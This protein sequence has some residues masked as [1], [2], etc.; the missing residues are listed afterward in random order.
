LNN[1]EYSQL[2]EKSVDELISLVKQ[3]DQQLLT[4]TE[5]NQ[6]LNLMLDNMSEHNDTVTE[7]LME[8]NEDLQ[9]MI[10][11][12]SEHADALAEDLEQKRIL[13]RQTFGRYLSDEIVNTLLDDENGLKLGGKREQI[14]LL[15]S[16]IRGFTALSEIQE[17]EIVVKILNY[18]LDNME[19]I[20]TKYNGTIDEFMGDGI[21]V[22]FG[23]P[24]QRE[25]DDKRAIA[26]AIE[27]QLCMP[28]INEQMKQWGLP[29]L[30]MGIGINTG[31]VVVGNIGSEN[32][33]KYGVVGSSVNLTYRI[34]SYTLGGQILISQST[35]D[36]V[37]ECIE[38]YD[39]R[40]ITPKGVKESVSIY[41][42]KSIKDKYN[43]QLNHETIV[44]EE[45][46]NKIPLHYV[47]LDGKQLGDDVII[48]EISHFSD[49]Y[50]YI[51]GVTSDVE[52]PQ[53][54]TNI[55]IDSMAGNGH[56]DA[57]Y[58]KVITPE[59]ELMGN[60]TFSDTGVFICFTSNDE[61]VRQVLG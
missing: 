56:K 45:L 58:A 46:K 13:I 22:L 6:D 43:L 25:D 50:A 1:I 21:L 9:L 5:E 8:D 29:K 33:S 24:T 12:T 3:L 17:P 59:K 60:N 30:E 26:C 2:H 52:M 37:A 19:K 27:M 11:T 48:G 10:E 41:S 42:V 34:E 40:K 15:T 39:V 28:K 47:I 57:L 44:L 55:K 7:E 32:R 4:V 36:D 18:Y 16:D 14:T 38:Y 53:V 35:Y 49:K 31:D 23:A 51:S 20:I 54:Y 61:V